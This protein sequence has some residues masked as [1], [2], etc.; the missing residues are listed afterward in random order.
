MLRLDELQ[1]AGYYPATD[2][3]S[4]VLCDPTNGTDSSFSNGFSMTATWTPAALSTA[5][6]CSCRNATAASVISPVQD[7]GRQLSRCL[8]CPANTTADSS[9]GACVPSSGPVQT[10]DSDLAYVLNTLNAQGAA[11]STTTATQVSSQHQHAAYSQ[12]ATGL[13]RFVT[14][15]Y[16][17]STQW[18]SSPQREISQDLTSMQSYVPTIQQ[19][20]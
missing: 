9:S 16:H 11:I 2:Q 8:T 19:Q 12:S 6:K 10:P 1:A 20:L 4:C 3:L 13:K 7:S 15:Q 5:G 17:N 18:F 14:E